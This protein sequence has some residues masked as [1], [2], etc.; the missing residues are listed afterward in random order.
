MDSTDC[1][2]GCVDDNGKIEDDGD[3]DDDADDEKVALS[4][5]NYV[6][7]R[8]GMGRKSATA[9]VSPTSLEG[10]RYQRHRQSLSVDWFAAD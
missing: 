7:L 5:G 6:A 4:F 3:D 9:G 1:G 8:I 10:L 2:D